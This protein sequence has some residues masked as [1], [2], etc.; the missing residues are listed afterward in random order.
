MSTWGRRLAIAAAGAATIG[1]VAACGDDGE[2][3]V[4]R[5]PADHRTVQAAVDAAV[6]GDL[7]LV[8]PGV[9]HEAVTI[10]TNAITLRGTDRNRVVL[11]GDGLL[12][13]G[14][15]VSADGVAVEN[16]TVRGYRQNGIVFNGASSA[17]EPAA[18]GV[19]GTETSALVGYRVS[20]VTAADNGLYGIYAF[21][22]RDGL[23]EHSYASGNPDSG[24]YVGQCQPCNVVV[25]DSIAEY[26]AIGYYGTNASGDVYVVNSVF[27]HNRLG[28]TPNSQDMELL[29]PQIETVIAGNLVVANDNPDAPPIARGFF[30]GGIAIGG[31]TRNTVVR[32][33]VLD[34][35]VFGIGVMSLG[36]FSP[37]GNTVEGNVVEGNGVDLFFEHAAGATSAEGNCFAANAFTT[38]APADIEVVLPCGEPANLAGVAP[39]GPAGIAAPPAGDGAIPRPPDQPNRPGDPARVP[40]EAAGLPTF[41]DIATIRVPDGP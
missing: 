18:G 29:A 36:E 33:R 5:V 26:N 40:A 24:I 27:R 19:Y 17:R 37:A 8:E 28:M 14:V 10:S 25:T 3:A 32:N 16:L 15:A 12:V 35:D 1:P 34:H 20:Y 39:T 6:A 4:R 2:S 38:S 9:Y 41:P 22:A 7:V 11:D 21:A 13:D 31:G 23:I 30:G